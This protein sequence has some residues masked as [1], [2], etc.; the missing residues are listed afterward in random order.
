MAVTKPVSFKNKEQDLVNFIQGKDFSYY[1]KELIRRDMENANIN[2][3]NR[4]INII[5]HKKR[6]KRITDYDI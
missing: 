6:N 2:A 1:V 5:E 4:D 3:M